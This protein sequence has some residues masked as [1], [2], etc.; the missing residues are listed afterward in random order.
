MTALDEA[1]VDEVCAGT[2]AEEAPSDG[3]QVKVS[4]HSSAADSTESP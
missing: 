3:L 1:V 2:D 4:P